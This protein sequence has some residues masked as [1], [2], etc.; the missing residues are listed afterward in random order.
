MLYQRVVSEFT[1]NELDI[2]AD[3]ENL[4]AVLAFVDERLEAANCPMKAKMQIDLAVEEIFVNIANYAYRPNK[5]RAVI[6]AEVRENPLE[7]TLTFLDSGAPYDPLAKEDP[8]I[9][10]DV[11]DRQIGGLGIFL[12]KQTMD[13]V[14]YEYKNGRNILTLTKNL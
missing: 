13:D 5:G 1:R 14:K 9:T 4:D 8:D 2:E 3:T 6:R 7:V 12:V 11:K 10:L